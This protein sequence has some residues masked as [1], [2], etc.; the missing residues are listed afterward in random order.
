MNLALIR[1]ARLERILF[2]RELEADLNFAKGRQTRGIYVLVAGLNAKLASKLTVKV[3][4][5]P[6]V[7]Y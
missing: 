1:M 4:K 2:D 7:Q 6:E 3:S 5:R